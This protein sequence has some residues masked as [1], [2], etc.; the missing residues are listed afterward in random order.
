MSDANT[1]GETQQTLRHFCEFAGAIVNKDRTDVCLKET[2]FD[3]DD[4]F[5]RCPRCSRLCEW[6]PEEAVVPWQGMAELNNNVANERE[7]I[8]LRR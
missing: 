8:D 6:E 3:K 4:S 2:L 1:L 7:P 5:S